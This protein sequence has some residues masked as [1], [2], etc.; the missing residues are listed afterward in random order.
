MIRVRALGAVSPIKD[1][2][3]DQQNMLHDQQLANDLTEAFGSPGS[4]RG[5]ADADSATEAGLLDKRLE[6]REGD[7]LSLVT[8]WL[9]EVARKLDMLVQ[10]H[11]DRDEA[12]KIT[13]PQGEFYQAVKQEDYEEIQGEFQYS[14]DVGATRPRLPDVERAQWIAFLS[15]VVVPLP[16]I[17][18]QPRVMK[19]MAEMFHIED[20]AALEEFRKMGEAILQGQVPQPG[21]QGGGPSNNPVAAVLGA[22]GG[23]GGG[24]VNGGG[25]Q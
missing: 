22:A 10:F 1:A 4:S 7:R 9:G 15:Q 21:Q 25:A 23:P 13:G 11:I 5:L 16:H 3:L 18:T 8:E 14:V 17:L 6:V 2:P 24:N 20:E 12:V 19:R